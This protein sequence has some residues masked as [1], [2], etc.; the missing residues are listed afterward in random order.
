MFCS[1]C[2]A[3]SQEGS[4]FCSSCGASLEVT[5]QAEEQAAAMAGEL[6]E[7]ETA[8]ALAPA[9]I[10]ME[11]DEKPESREKEDA[12]VQA[13]TQGGVSTANATAPRVSGRRFL[14]LTYLLPA[15]SVLIIVILIGGLYGYQMSVNRQVDKLQ[16]QGESLALEGKLAEGMAAIEKAL[17]K[18][19][20]HKVLLADRELLTDALSLQARLDDTDKQWK[21]KKFDDAIKAIDTLDKELATRNGPVFQKLASLADEK[22]E[23]IVV[24][25]VS[26]D[27][28][29]K[30]TVEAL[31]PLFNTVKD[32]SG[33]EAQKTSKKIRQKIIDLSYDKASDK[34]AEKQFAEALTTIETA[35]KFDDGNSKLTAL[36]TK[37]EQKKKAFE[38]AE[39]NRIQ[40]A[41]EAAN[42]E[43]LN[44]RTQAV[45]LLTLNAYTDDSGYFVVEGT[46]KN[47]AMRPI[48]YILVYYDLLDDAGNVIDSD[49]IYVSPT[50]L[51]VGKTGSFY[52]DYDNL[53]GKSSATVTRVEWEIN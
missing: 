2:G 8:A 43:D 25:Q 28:A 7:E 18:R 22:R 30:T 50:D 52:M 11:A 9:P 48:S 14:S 41:I 21:S 6:A 33:D 42:Q 5:A 10:I 12:V 37:V 40:K 4:K 46:V 31:I 16:Q 36:R 24:A 13:T 35:L 3:K 32:Y 47:R 26:G 53:D 49:S 17:G 34:L 44:N 27:L 15:A 23:T 39:N 29:V 19:P 20:D 51:D 1:N 38:D 45:E